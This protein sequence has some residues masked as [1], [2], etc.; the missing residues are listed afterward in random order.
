LLNQFRDGILPTARQTLEVSRQAYNVGEVDFL[1]L[2]DNWRQLLKYEISYR[3]LEA[4]LRQT[5]AKLEQ[6]VGGLADP[7][8]GPVVRSGDGGNAGCRYCAP[9]PLPYVPYCGCR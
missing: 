5:L 8:L 2:I 6:V 9:P 3:R 4:S 1:Q 7:A